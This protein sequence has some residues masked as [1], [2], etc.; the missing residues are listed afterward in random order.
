MSANRW[1]KGETGRPFGLCRWMSVILQ[2]KS[3]RSVGPKGDGHGLEKETRLHINEEQNEEQDKLAQQLE[4]I[5]SFD[6][7]LQAKV[8]ENNRR[9]KERR[10]RRCA[11]VA[12]WEVC[13]VAAGCRQKDVEEC[14]AVCR[15]AKDRA[16]GMVDE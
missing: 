2:T 7:N 8:R 5:M 6:S 4:V 16:N 3:L 12:Q 14:R 11:V 10:E 13:S 9:E 1:R 15:R